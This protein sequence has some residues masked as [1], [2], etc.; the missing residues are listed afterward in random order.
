MFS[1][2]REIFQRT[3]AFLGL[4]NNSILALLILYKSPKK[5]GNYKYLMMYISIFE[6][7]YS[8]LDFST[9]PEIFSKD[10]AFLITIEKRLAVLP[11]IALQFALS[12][13][14]VKCRL[15]KFEISVVFC[16]LFGMSMA[17]FAIHFVY[18]YLVMTGW[19]TNMD[20]ISYF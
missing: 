1:N 18:R 17:I 20:A 3:C 7:I 9:V 5:L 19:V 2:Y 6:I 13:F 11:D 15:L 14:P 4:F 16:S 8:L 10:S 12:E